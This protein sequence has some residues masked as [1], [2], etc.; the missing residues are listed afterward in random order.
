MNWYK[1]AN[2]YLEQL[3]EETKKYKT[4]EEFAR[5]YETLYHGGSENIIGDK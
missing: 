4:P 3:R 2:K 1:K 5:D